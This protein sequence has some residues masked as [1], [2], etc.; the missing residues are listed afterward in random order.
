M[1]TTSMWAV[2][3]RLGKI[4]L[5][6]ENP[7]KTIDTKTVQSETD[8]QSLYDV[9]NYAM[10][11]NK[12]VDT[13]SEGTQAQYVTGINCTATGARDQ[14]MLTKRQYN[15]EGGIV[16]YHGY[17]SFKEG[18]VTPG[19]AHSLGVQLA[20]ELW[21]DRFEIVVATHLDRN[22]T[23]NHFC[24]NSVSFADGNR[25]RCNKTTYGQMKAASDRLCR[26]NNL[27][28]INE[29]NYDNSKQY[30]EWRA[31]D[32]GRLTWKEELRT[33][34]NYAIR[35]S[36]TKE[37][38]EQNL[39]DM[40]Y[41]IKWGKELSIL[42]PGKER[43]LRPARQFGE[44][45]STERILEQVQ[46]QNRYG[47]YCKARMRL[48]E[49]ERRHIRIMLRGKDP[50]SMATRYYHYG[51]RIS[52]FATHKS[53]DLNPFMRREVSY[54]HSIIRQIELLIKMVIDTIEQL[55]KLRADTKAKQH[56]LYKERNRLYKQISRTND[57]AE[58]AFLRQELK[59]VG[60]EYKSVREIVTDCDA[61]IEREP[62]LN[63]HIQRLQPIQKQRDGWERLH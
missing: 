29:P 33:D 24:V 2:K 38:L 18:E 21:G 51:L 16:A 57:P 48:S 17:R 12:T 11:T 49:P 45:Y 26:E 52:I 54:L 59:R 60:I 50:D 40:G 36:R 55:L 13:E 42:A 32:S 20:K 39:L 58:I 37:Q 44:Q 46:A 1:A 63:E 8:T 7:D 3:G 47:T 10:S 22:C 43:Y 56:P 31:N 25:F 41:Q 19:L 27:S 61:I 6:V 53:S 30:G 4:V 34:L 28:V 23:H 62:K 5:Y 35:R 14:M 9:I 15:K